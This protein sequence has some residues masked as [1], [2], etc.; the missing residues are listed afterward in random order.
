LQATKGAKTFRQGAKT[1]RQDKE[2]IKSEADII[3]RGAKHYADT[4]DK[5]YI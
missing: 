5:Y 2:E 4:S 3:T 1:F